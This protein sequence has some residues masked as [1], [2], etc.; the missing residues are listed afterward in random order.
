MDKATFRETL[1]LWRGEVDDA[2]R[3]HLGSMDGRHG[4]VPSRLKEAMEYAVFSGGKRVRPVMTLA[5]CE[6]VGGARKLAMPS[7]CA[8]EMIHA[9]SLIH[10]DLPSM[11]DDDVRRGK[12]TVH[13]QYDIPT[14]ILA[15]DALQSEAFRALSRPGQ[16]VEA[17]AQ[18]RLIELVSE[19]AGIAG[20][21]GGQQ[22]DI[23]AEKDAPDMEGVKQLHNMKTG[24]LFLASVLCGGVA[25]GASEEELATL[26]RY[27]RAVGRAFQVTDDILDLL[28]DGSEGKTGDAHEDAVNFAV[29]MGIDAARE[30]AARLIATAKEAA[31]SFG[32]KG[33]VLYQIAVFIEERDH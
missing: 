25:G 4:R 8:L 26:D 17:A 33:D 5:A 1:S 21:V 13:I 23:D 29:Q 14:A 7:A 24:A 15:G 20:M 30:E 22:Y 28:E 11:D 6:A 31:R 3:G 19:A 2:L 32:D 12:P 9:Y 27:G 18:V 10:D 16:E